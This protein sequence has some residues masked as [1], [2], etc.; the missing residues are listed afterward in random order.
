MEVLGALEIPV[1]IKK[2]LLNKYDGFITGLCYRGETSHYDIVSNY[3]AKALVDW[4]LIIQF[5]YQMAF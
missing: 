5:R 4:Q 2:L 1:L 3:S